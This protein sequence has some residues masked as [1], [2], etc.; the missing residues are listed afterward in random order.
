MV[1][2]Y[3]YEYDAVLDEE[4]YEKSKGKVTHERFMGAIIS[5][6]HLWRVMIKELLTH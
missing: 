5:R 4:L 6:L 3:G 1:K 2:E